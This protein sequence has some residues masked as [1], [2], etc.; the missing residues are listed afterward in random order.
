MLSQPVKENADS[1]KDH[2]LHMI[3]E[4]IFAEL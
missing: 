4:E 1:P 2:D 3:E